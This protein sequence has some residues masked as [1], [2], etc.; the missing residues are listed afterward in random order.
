M[1]AQNG[2]VLPD[3]RLDIVIVAIQSNDAAV[4]R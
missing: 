4:E 2:I 1:L 3:S